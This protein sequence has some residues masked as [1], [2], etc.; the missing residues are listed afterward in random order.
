MKTLIAY[1]SKNGCTAQCAQTLAQTL[2]GEVVA[3]DLAREK[4]DLSQYDAVILGAPIYI[5]NILGKAKKF[6]AANTQQLLQ[7]KLGLFICCCDTEKKEEQLANAYPE[8]LRNHA[9]LQDSFGGRLDLQKQNFL[10]RA[11]L[12]KAMNITENMENINREA[13]ANFAEQWEK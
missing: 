1:A 13:I 11:M 6:C 12:K 5:G 8:E 7:K 9:V 10:T 3:C 4:P 2:S